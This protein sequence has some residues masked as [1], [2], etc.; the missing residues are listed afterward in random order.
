M[1][2][3]PADLAGRSGA[4]VGQRIKLEVP[5]A[6]P[7]PSAPVPS[8]QRIVSAPP[9]PSVPIVHESPIAITQ[10]GWAAPTTPQP[11]APTTPQP[12]APAT[13]QPVL[14]GTAH[15]TESR[16]RG[17]L[18]AV[19]DQRTECDVLHADPHGIWRLPRTAQREQHPLLLKNDGPGDLL[20][21]VRITGQGVAV[22][23][24]A[25]LRIPPGQQRWMLLHLER[26]GDEWCG[27]EFVTADTRPG[28]RCRLRLHAPNC[29]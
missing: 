5:F 12:T 16:P 27:V 21:G 7:T 25:R 3:P 17:R 22:A 28:R 1:W 14:V 8:P 19:V 6:C 20:V 23:P 26:T 29:G 11:T 15:P 18:A 2:T 24:S 13:P 10:V 9:P 4:P